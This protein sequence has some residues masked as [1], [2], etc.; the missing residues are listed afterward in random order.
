MDIQNFI[1]GFFG[2]SLIEII[3][4]LSGFICVYLIIK[5]SLWCWPVGLLQVT[6]YLFVFYDAKLYSDVILQGIYIVMQIYGWW[7]WSQGR[8]QDHDVIVIAGSVTGILLWVAV[9]VLGSYAL[10]Y[11]MSTYTDAALP[12]PDAFIT[13]TSLIAQWL[14]SRRILANWMF[15]IMV[16]LV[17]IN[18]Y[19]QK[20]LYP[21]TVLYLVFLFMA[22]S[23]L[24]VW[25]RQL[26]LQSGTAATELAES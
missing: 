11:I 23:G 18:V 9:A 4:S 12:Y 14:L 22:V 7:Y 24:I 17:A 13:V 1:I 15:W 20:D 3:A 8:K 6:L 19:W 10:G 2:A 25:W 5:R 26:S 16:D 21:T